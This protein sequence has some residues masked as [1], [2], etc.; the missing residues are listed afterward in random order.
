MLNYKNIVQLANNNVCL[1]SEQLIVTLY[2][3]YFY[4]SLHIIRTLFEA[5]IVLFF[6]SSCQGSP[7]ALDTL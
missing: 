3:L 1:G 4:P 2:I 7:F 6:T 5:H